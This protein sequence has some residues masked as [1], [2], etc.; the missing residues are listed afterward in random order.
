MEVEKQ[1]TVLCY[2]GH[3]DSRGRSIPI[4]PPM[5]FSSIANACQPAS[6]SDKDIQID[7]IHE[8]SGRIS[9]EV[10]VLNPEK[11]AL[12]KR[13]STWWY[14]QVDTGRTDVIVGKLSSKS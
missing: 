6:L 11:I 1:I 14:P 9:F 4:S 7:N 2:H 13:R 12:L 8:M 3:K 5:I 10:Q